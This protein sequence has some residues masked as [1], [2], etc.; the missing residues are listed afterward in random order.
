[1][2]AAVAAFV[3]AAAFMVLRRLGGRHR[4]IALDRDRSAFA[5]G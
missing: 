3:T 2:A 4:R 1:M 5:I